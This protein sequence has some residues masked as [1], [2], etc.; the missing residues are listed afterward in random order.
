MDNRT[1]DVLDIGEFNT[2]GFCPQYPLRRHRYESLA[3]AGCHE[4]RQDW[5]R[6]IRPAE[7]FG[8]CNPVNGNFAA[9]VLPLTLPERLSLVAYIL[10]YAFLHDNVVETVTPVTSTS[11]SDEFRLGEAERTQRNVQTGRKQIQAKMML[12]LLRTDKACAER[13][14]K[15]WKIM[16]A[17]T[18]KH[19]SDSFSS[20][21]EYL[22]YRII[23]TGAPFVESV[24]LFGM[25]MTLTTEEDNHL[26]EVVRPC[27]ASLA[28]A[29]DYFSFDREWEEVQ[30]GGPAPTNAVW[31]CMRWHS[32]NVQTAKKLV[33]AAANRYEARFLELCEGF[34]RGNPICSEKLDR[35]LR[36]LT[37]QVSGNVVWSLTCPRYHPEFRY[38]PNAGIEDILTAKARGEGAAR[39]ETLTAEHRQSIASLS[40]HPT[41][42]PYSTSESDWGS[43]R[44]S[45]FSDDWTD[46]YQEGEAVKLPVEECLG[47]KVRRQKPRRICG[48]SA[49][50]FPQHVMAPFQY[51]ASLP[52]KGVRGMFIDALNMWC[53]LP[54]ATLAKIKEVIDGLHTASL[55]FDDIEDGSALRRGHPAAHAVYGVAQ[56]INAASFAMVDAVGKARDIPISGAV[57]IVLDELRDLHI[58]QSYDIRWTRHV[59]CPSEAEYLEMVTK[60]TGGLFRLFS[61]L[62]TTNL[63]E[64]TK[65]A[66]NDLVAQVG[67]YFQIRDDLQNLNSDEYADQKGFCEDLDEGKLSFPLVYYLNNVEDTLC[68]REIIQQRREDKGLNIHLKKLVLQQLKESASLEYTEKTLKQLEVRIDDII[69]RLERITGRKNW[70]LRLCMEKLKV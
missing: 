35:Y 64:I 11:N 39:N 27:Y 69:A 63:P 18:L 17:T 28:L 38:D 22:D 7:A 61:R 4:A 14:I 13:V 49:Y 37:Y 5:T 8:N 62:M 58:G 1:S 34:R 48:L 66:I 53:D 55:M 25:G 46:G 19:K 56:T 29:N 31:L 21:E 33:R 54:D 43:S 44:S 12:Q 3:N 47:I 15:V 45:S 60:K 67:I 30:N 32:V 24:M 42:S 52:S 51:V 23:D 2:H 40:S 41:D 6:Y 16:L 68:L 50:P 36:G 26:A 59:S 57:N 65:S 9:L 20:L 70:V 10:E